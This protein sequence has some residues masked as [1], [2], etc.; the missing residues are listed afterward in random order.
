M[1]RARSRG[2]FALERRLPLLDE[3]GHASF[4]SS[5][6]NSEWNSRRSSATPVASV[7]S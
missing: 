6:A 2:Y 7:V 1:R 5:K 4:W 3:G